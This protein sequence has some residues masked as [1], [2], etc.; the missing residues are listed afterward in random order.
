MRTVTESWDVIDTWLTKHAP[1]TLPELRGPADPAEIA[2]AEARIGRRFPA[3]LTESLSRHDGLSQNVLPVADYL[4]VAVIVEYYEMRMENAADNDGFTGDPE[5]W[6]SPD[7]I[8]FADENGNIQVIDLKSG[9]LGTAFCY[10]HGNFGDIWGWPS[11][12]AYLDEVATA[13]A[14]GGS[15]RG[16]WYPYLR[17]TKGEL[18]WGSEDDAGTTVRRK[19]LY[20][21]PGL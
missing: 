13:L 1:L 20:P 16:E 6:W 19:K 10:S 9:R 15:I 3:E 11:T 12:P 7:W 4:S 2:A 8:P 21:A 5:P 17:G 14:T 18:M